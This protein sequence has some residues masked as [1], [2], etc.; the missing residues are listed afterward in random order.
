MDGAVR[1][2]SRGSGKH[3][4]LI[5]TLPSLHTCLTR[6]SKCTVHSQIWATPPDPRHQAKNSHLD[7]I[8]L[9]H[10]AALPAWM[11]HGLTIWHCALLLQSLSARTC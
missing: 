1:I 6:P 4:R 8:W 3:F 10:L 11:L 2:C 9:G 5:Q 7:L